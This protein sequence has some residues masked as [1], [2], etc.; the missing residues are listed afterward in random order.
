[1]PLSGTA[2]SIPILSWLVRSA[3]VGV[4]YIHDRGGMRMIPLSRALVVLSILAV[5]AGV[6][7]QQLPS[8]SAH[9]SYTP[10]HLWSSP[11]PDQNPYRDSPSSRFKPDPHATSPSTHL[12]V[13]GTTDVRRYGLEKA[14]TLPQPEG[15]TSIQD[16]SQSCNN[17]D[18]GR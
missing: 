14:A 12:T 4:S 6:N 16:S 1:M 3:D 7:A 9:G 5:G 13:P 11:A 10:S 2:Q 15:R 17:P 8:S 18:C